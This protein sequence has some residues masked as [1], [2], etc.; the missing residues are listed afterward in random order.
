[1]KS[2]KKKV[3]RIKQT[4]L[5]RQFLIESLT[6]MLYTLNLVKPNEEIVDIK[7]P[8]TLGNE[9]PIEIITKEVKV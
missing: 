6:P 9:I 5:G 3:L 1:M 8:S 2:K 7:F 4:T